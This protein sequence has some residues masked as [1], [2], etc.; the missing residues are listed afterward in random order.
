VA[1]DALPGRKFPALLQ[2]VDPLVDANGR[3]VGVRGCIDNRSMQLRP[4]MFARV[5]AV[6]GENANAMVLPEE[7]LVPQGGRQ[8]VYKVVAGEGDTKV[9]QR[10]EVKLG[11]RVPG[12][13]EILEG[14]AVGDVV[15]IAGQQRLQRDGTPVRV[16][17]TPARGGPGG[18]G[19]PGGAGGAGG[20]A[21]A[22]SGAASAA[23]AAT[24]GPRGGP[25][26]RMAGG[27]GGRAGAAARPEGPNPCLQAMGDAAGDGGA[28][29][30]GPRGPRGPQGAPAAPTAPRAPGPQRNSAAG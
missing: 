21:A 5:T 22:A 15:V 9:S 13:V 2:A 29:P 27:P 16:I 20:P 17:E 7:A 25:G 24:A 10:T 30:S 1:I 3:S 19:G 18:S 26:A 23:S 11:L 8:V 28:A 12:K 6:F 4:G 14:L